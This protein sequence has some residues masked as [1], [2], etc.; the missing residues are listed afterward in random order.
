[1][2][3]QIIDPSMLGRSEHNILRMMESEANQM[4]IQGHK[5]VMKITEVD[6]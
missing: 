2:G 1:M 6:Y 4:K 3:I 5:R